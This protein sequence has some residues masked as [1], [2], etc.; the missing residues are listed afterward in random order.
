MRD[1]PLIFL[2]NTPPDDDFLSAHGNDGI[3]V[4][5]RAQMMAAVACSQVHHIDMSS[6]DAEE[7]GHTLSTANP[8]L[9]V[10]VWQK[11]VRQSL[12]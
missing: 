8:D 6:I 1:I 4:K 11:P 2:Q 12:Y 7:V 5:A 9:H 10:L 3:T